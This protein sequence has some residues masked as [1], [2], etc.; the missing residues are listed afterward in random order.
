MP[1]V[2]LFIQ[3]QPLPQ[4]RHLQYQDLFLLQSLLPLLFRMQMFNQLHS[5]FPLLLGHTGETNPFQSILAL[6]GI[7]GE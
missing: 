3:T 2:Q 7:L 5:F 4:P 6:N 1:K